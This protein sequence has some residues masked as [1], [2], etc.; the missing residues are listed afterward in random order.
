MVYGYARK[1]DD[2]LDLSIGAKIVYKT[3][4]MKDNYNVSDLDAA[5]NVVKIDIEKINEMMPS[6]KQINKLVVTDEPM[7]KTTT[8]KV[9]RFEEAKNL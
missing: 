8:G 7:V 3:D 9:K 4:V 2:P 5:E 6:Y 1:E